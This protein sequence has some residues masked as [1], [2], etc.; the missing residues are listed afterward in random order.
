MMDIWIWSNGNPHKTQNEYAGAIGQVTQPEL[1]NVQH[2]FLNTCIPLGLAMDKFSITRNLSVHR[3][4]EEGGF[5]GHSQFIK[6]NPV[7]LRTSYIVTNDR[8]VYEIEPRTGEGRW[9]KNAKHILDIDP[10][11]YIA[12]YPTGKR[13]NETTGF[14]AYWL[15]R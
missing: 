9:R 13:W 7:L 10:S 2:I 12:N 1:T 11:P 3:V 8:Q 15:M 14:L 4:K 6:W 5:F